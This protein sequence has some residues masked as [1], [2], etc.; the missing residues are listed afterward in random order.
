VLRIMLL[1]I[2][3]VCVVGVLLDPRGNIVL[4]A[5][6]ILFAIAAMIPSGRAGAKVCFVLV[7]VLWIAGIVIP[8]GFVLLWPMAAFC[9]FRVVYYFLFQ[10]G[11]EEPAL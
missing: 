10:R 7:P 4:V 6:G 2:A 11:R 1:V 5:P 9:F 3:M 8:F